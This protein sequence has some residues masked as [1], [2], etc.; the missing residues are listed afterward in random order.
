[1]IVVVIGGVVAILLLLEFL[2]KILAQYKLLLDVL[3]LIPV[4]EL[5]ELLKRIALGVMLEAIAV[6]V[7]SHL[8]VFEDVP[9]EILAQ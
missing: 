8:P 5:E 4:F 9:L 7:L 3:L 2:P 1:M 6:V